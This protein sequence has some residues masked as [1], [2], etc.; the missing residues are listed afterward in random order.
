MYKSHGI[1]SGR[2]R[3][4]A[5]IMVEDYSKGLHTILTRIQD[6]HVSTRKHYGNKQTMEMPSVSNSYMLCW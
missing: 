6:L 5:R 2:A 1:F 4:R 3:A